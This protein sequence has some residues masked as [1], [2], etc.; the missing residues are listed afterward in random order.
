[1]EE[2]QDEES[3]ALDETDNKI[4]EL[5]DQ[6]GRM[7]YRQIS[8]E[9]D[10][11]VGTIHNRVDKLM[12]TGV[13]KK[14]I[15]FLDHNK[16][17]YKLTAIIGVRV[18]GGVLKNWETKTA[19]HKNVLGVYD[20]TGEYDAILLAKFRDTTELDGFIKDLLKEPGVQ[21]TYTQTVLNIVK[22]DLC[23]SRMI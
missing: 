5:L 6:D 19:Y 9:L 8:R 15:P 16:L 10:I 18:K 23:S 14:F 20:V 22:E 21:R 13:I 12:K 2:Y 17:G 3:I 7:S 4:I 11:S 1:M